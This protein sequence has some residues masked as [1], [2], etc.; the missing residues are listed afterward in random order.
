MHK[1]RAGPQYRRN[2]NDDIWENFRSEIRRLYLGLEDSES[3]CP[4]ELRVY[5]RDH[6]QFE[7]TY[8]SQNSALLPSILMLESG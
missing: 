4:K 5:F 8:V 1:T 2:I 7:P 6:R 3:Y